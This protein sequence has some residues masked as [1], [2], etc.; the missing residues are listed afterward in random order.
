[1]IINSLQSGKGV[2]NIDSRCDNPVTNEAI[3]VPKV[4]KRKPSTGLLYKAPKA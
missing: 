2:Q 4:S 1:M 3:P